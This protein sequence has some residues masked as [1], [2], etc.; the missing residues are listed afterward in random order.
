MNSKRSLNDALDSRQVFSKANAASE[1]PETPQA[2]SVVQT[3]GLS[4]SLKEY[5]GQVQMSRTP[6]NSKPVS[7]RQFAGAAGA[8]LAAANMASADIVHV[9]LDEP[10][11]IQLPTFNSTSTF[12]TFSTTTST[13]IDL[14][15]F[16]VPDVRIDLRRYSG[17]AGLGSTNYFFRA[18]N[19]YGIDGGVIQEQSF[20]SALRLA[21]GEA[22]SSGLQ[23]SNDL[24]LGGSATTGSGS[25]SGLGFGFGNWSI[26]EP[27]Y[28]GVKFQIN[29]QDHFAWIRIT[30]DSGENGELAS[31]F[32]DEWAYEDI[33]GEAIDAGETGSLAGDYNG[34]GGVDVNDYAE[35]KLQFGD[36]VAVPGIGADGN[37]D[38]IV[39]AA[40]YTVWRDNLGSSGPSLGNAAPEPVSLG[41]L[42][43]GAVGV[44]ALRRRKQD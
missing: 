12:S 8:S 42:A 28:A 25:G 20:G 23:T 27:G 30:L 40:D 17:T 33:P 14:N 10:I 24:A 7:W 1:L 6:G 9:V 16:D 34:D 5:R 22:I 44:A 13:F 41:M 38:G 15:E 21:S 37:R 43:L 4:R 11:S 2:R 29:G 31:V 32:I 35:W 19:I 39:D 18:A 3:E 26:S 36:I